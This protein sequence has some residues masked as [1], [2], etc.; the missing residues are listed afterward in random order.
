MGDFTVMEFYYRGISL[1]GDFIVICFTIGGFSLFHCK[2][3]IFPLK[4]SDSY[5]FIIFSNFFYFCSELNRKKSFQSS[6]SYAPFCPDKT[7]ALSLKDYQ[8]LQ[9]HEQY[10]QTLRECGFNQDEIQFKL[11]QEG[12]VPKVSSVCSVKSYRPGVQLQPLRGSCFMRVREVGGKSNVNVKHE[13]GGEGRGQQQPHTDF[14]VFFGI[15]VF[16]L[17]LPKVT[18]KNI[19]PQGSLTGGGR[20]QECRP[21]WSRIF[22]VYTI[23]C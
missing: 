20:L 7:G 15:L 1:L 19:K 10:V 5:I 18:E 2:L 22:L 12:Y 13:Q 4:A 21:Y 16:L 23:L 11:E 6:S 3:Q 8:S 17:I 14:V 9:S